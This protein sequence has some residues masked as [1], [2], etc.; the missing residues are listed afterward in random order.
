MKTRKMFAVAAVAGLALVG[1]AST[2]HAVSGDVAPVPSIIIETGE[3]YQNVMT[4]SGTSDVTT[5]PSVEFGE[6]VGRVAQPCAELDE[7]VR[8]YIEGQPE[9]CYLNRSHLA[10]IAPTPA[11]DALGVI[12]T[13]GPQNIVAI[14]GGLDLGISQEVAPVDV[15]E[16]EGTGIMAVSGVVDVMPVAGNVDDAAT[17]GTI[18]AVSLSA[19]AVAGVGVMLARKPKT[20]SN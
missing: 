11:G 3:G 17:S 8:E 15:P 5:L 2:A 19:V 1:G 13:D 16:L 18:L 12:E 10:R 9:L 14:S 7:S 4:L 20:A 6:I